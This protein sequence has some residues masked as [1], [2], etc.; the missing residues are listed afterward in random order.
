[1][2]SIA[3]RLAKLSPAK[4]AL[5]QRAKNV[6]EKEQFG[7]VD[8]QKRDRSSGRDALS[9]A[10]QRLWFLDQLE[11][12]NA[13]YNMP[14]AI[15]L[16]GQLDY[17][18]LQRVFD[19]IIQRH[20]SLRTNFQSERGQP[21]QI[22]AKSAKLHISHIDLS[23]LDKGEIE[24]QLETLLRLEAQKP[25]NLARD[26]LLRVSVLRLSKLENV[27]SVTIHHII[28]DGWSVGNVLLHEFKTLYEAF[29]KGEPSP[30]P[31]LKIQYADFASWQRNWL[32][33]SRL[34]NQLSYWKNKLSGVPALIDL[35][36]DRPRPPV[37]TFSG[38][39]HNF[40]LPAELLSEVKALSQAAGCTLFMT[41]L[42][43]FSALLA[44]YSRQEDVVVGS[45]IANRNHPDLEPL[46]G[47]FVNTLV[48]RTSL[49]PETT[50]HELLAQ[51]R[52]NCLEAFQNQDVP[53]ERLVEHLKPERNPSF[54]PL[55]QVMFILQT[56][57]QERTGLK[58]GDL[59]M[60]SIPMDAATSMFDLTL[61]LEEQGGELLGE[62][63]YN[64]ALFD[65]SWIERFVGYYTNMLKG[66][67]RSRD[68]LVARIPLMSESQTKAV[69]FET[70]QTHQ[71]LPLEQSVVSLF[72]EQARQSPN[73]LAVTMGDQSM[74][75]SELNLA[76]EKF[77]SYLCNK[78]VGVETLVGLCLDRSLNMMVG[79]L[80]ILKAGAAY[81]PLDPDYPKERLAAMIESSR[82]RIIVA[83]TATESCLPDAIQT[84]PTDHKDGR[85]AL[86]ILL[87]RDWN[88]ILNTPL[89]ASSPSIAPESLA[90]VIFTSGSTGKPKGVQISHQALLNF[91]LTMQEQPGLKAE[92]VLL[93][94]T[95][96]SFDIA[97]LELYLP[98]ITGA[99]IVLVS[100]ETASDGFQLLKE[101]EAHRPTVMQATPSTW[102]MLLATG[103]KTF[104]MR[105]I[106]CGGEALDSAL[107]NQLVQTGAQIW[108]LYGPTETT[109]WSM[110]NEVK[111]SE[112]EKNAQLGT[113][114]AI[115]KPIGNTQTYILDESLDPSSLGLSGELYI[116]GLGVSRGYLGQPGLTAERFLPDPYSETPGARIY[117]TGDLVRAREEGVITYV[118][119]IDH[120]VKIRGFRIELGEIEATLA[121]H[122]AVSH[123]VA[124]ARPDHHGQ[125]QLVA[126]VETKP[127]WK[128]T[129]LAH[130]RTHA[131]NE[132]WQTVWNETY[133][134]TSVP[135]TSWDDLSGWL[136]SHTRQPIP[137]EEMKEWVT[138]TVS[139]I[140]ALKPQ[141]I[142]E[143][144]CGTGLLLSRL[145]PHV[146]Q[147][148]GLDFSREV[149][150]QLRT[151]LETQSFENVSLL[152][153]E[154]NDLHDIDEESVD[155]FVINSVAQ[156]FPNADYLI[157]AVLGA[158]TKVAD[159][160]RLFIGD[161]R[162]LQMLD[163]QHISVQLFQA[164][165]QCDKEELKKRI[166]AAIEREEE[167]LIH[168]RFF[169]A[170]RSIEPRIQSISLR[171]K[172]GRAHNEMTC[173]RYDL[174]MEI[175]RQP[176]HSVSAAT[177]QAALPEID[178]S[179]HA[180]TLEGLTQSLR[181]HPLGLCLRNVNNQRLQH[182]A[183]T[184]E[185]LNST[186]LPKDVAAF[187][188]KLAQS[189]IE[190]LSI[191][192]M[193]ELANTLGM[194]IGSAWSARQPHR[195]MDIV[196]VK[197]ESNIPMHGIAIEMVYEEAASDTPNFA[198]WTNYPDQNLS[199]Q[200]LT[201]SLRQSLQEALPAY[202]VP[203]S[204]VCLDK[205]P[206]T[207]NGKIDRLSLPAPDAVEQQAAYLAPRNEAEMHLVRIWEDILGIERIG[208]R[209]NF[210]NLG[211][212]SLLA[213]Q[214]ISKIRDYFSIELPLQA[215]FDAPTVGQLAELLDT[216]QPSGSAQAPVIRLLSEQERMHAP[217]SF[218]QQRLW[219]LNE[220]EGA[221]VTYH[222]S[223]AVKIKG[224]LVVETLER[225]FD[226]IVSRHETLRTHF[227]TING[228]PVAKLAPHQPF[229]I[230]RFSVLN[231]TKEQRALSVTQ[232]LEK[233]ATET[234]DLAQDLL[235]RVTLIQTDHHE[236]VMMLTLHHIISDEWSLA[237]LQ[238]EVAKLYAAFS[239]AQS[240]PLPPLPLQ[241]ADYAAWQRQ[242]M[243]RERLAEHLDY[244]VSEL[245]DAP[246]LLELPTDRPR[247]AVQ[248]YIGKTISFR[249]EPSLTSRLRTLGQSCG[250]TLFMT[251]LSGWSI[252][253]SRHARTNDLV[254]GSPV[255]N[256]S[257]SELE[258][259]IGFFVNTV[260]LRM[261]VDGTQSTIEL[262]E[263]NRQKVLDAFKHQD[264]PFE[265]IVEEIKPERNLSH[266]PIF[267]T[268]FVMQNA[269]SA[270][271]SFGG[272]ALEIL[273]QELRAAK[274]D[275]TL[276]IEEHASGLNGVI[277][278]NTD[279]FDASSINRMVE[280][281]EYVLAS[282]TQRPAAVIDSISLLSSYQ[283][284]QL[285]DNLHSKVP[286]ERTTPAKLDTI[287]PS[288][289]EQFNKH[290]LEQPEAIAVR[291]GPLALSYGELNASA[292]KLAAHLRNHG[293]HTYDIVGLYAEPTQEMII[294]LLAILKVGAAYLPLLPGT[295][296]ERLSLMLN[297][298]SAKLVVDATN[299]LST[300]PECTA[301][302]LTL[303]QLAQAQDRAPQ[304]WDLDEQGLAYVIY[305]SGSTGQPKGV[306]VTR[307][308]LAQAT[309]SR[310]NFYS[311]EFS[312]LI[313]LQPFSFDVATGNI[314]WTLCAGATLFM[315]PRSIA[316][317]PQ[318]LLD[319]L[320]R[321]QSSH[322]VL[323]PLLYAPLL[324]LATPEQL[325]ALRTVIVG[326]EQMPLP[327]VQ[328]HKE[329]VP[330]AGLFNEYGPTETT[331]MCCAY[332]CEAHDFEQPIPIGRP[333]PPSK[334][335]LLDPAHHPVPSGL[336]GE[337]CIG[338]P[339]VSMGYLGRPSLT[340]EHFLPD[341]F[342]ESP[343]ARMYRS[344]DLGK[345]NLQGNIEFLGR[346]DHQ[347]KIR[348]FRVELGEIEATLR[349]HPEV[350]ELAV[351]AVQ[352]GSSKRLIAYVVP[353]TVAQD[354][355]H[356]NLLH[357][358][359][360]FAQSLL[361][362]YMVPSAFVLM[363]ALPLTANGKLDQ[364]ALPS[365]DT[366]TP[367]STFTA[368]G[369]E[370]EEKLCKIWGDVLGIKQ[371]GIHDN[372]FMLGGD[373]ILSIQIVSRANQLGLGLSV[374]QLFQHQTIAKL[375]GLIGQGNNRSIEQGPLSGPFLLGPVQ[376]WFLDQ[377]PPEPHH[378]NQSLLLNIQTGLTED[379]L[380]KAFSAIARHHDM[381]RARFI[382]DTNGWQAHIDPI[383][384]C[385]ASVHC[386]DLRDLPV[387]DRSTAMIEH[388]RE[389]QA[390]LDLA[391]GPISTAI[392][393]RLSDEGP[394]KLLWI[395]HHLSVDGISWR[396]LLE[397]LEQALE[398]CH[399]QREISFQSKTDSF[400]TWTRRLAEHSASSECEAELNYWKN[401][402]STAV[403]SLP[404]DTVSVMDPRLN[405]KSSAQTLT[406]VLSA[407]LSEALL[408]KAPSTFRTQI[409]DVLLA[410]L[411]MAL[412]R[413]TGQDSA[414]I[415]LEGHGR[416]EL[417]ENIDISRT[418][419]W[420]T[421]G[422]PVLLTKTPGNNPIDNILHTKTLLQSIPNKGVG[423][424]ILSYLHPDQTVRESLHSGH[425]AQLS[426]NYLGQFKESQASTWILGEALEPTDQEHSPLGLRKPLIEINALHRRDQLEINWTFSINLHHT[427]TIDVL[428]EHFT[429]VLT[430]IV[431]LCDV[432][433]DNLQDL[434]P[435][436]PMQQGMLFH[437]QLG[438]EPGAY[439]IQLSSRMQGDFS[440]SL[441]T[442]A[443]QEVLDRH[444][445]LRAVI[446][447]PPG[448]D[449]LQGI[450]S[451]AKLPWFDFDWR[452]LSAEAQQEQWLAL[453]DAD[454]K[455]GFDAE[456]CPLMRCTLVQTE[457]HS[458]R[459]LWS[460]HHLLTDGWCLPILM[461]EVLECYESFACG[462]PYDAPLPPLYREYIEWLQSKDLNQAKSF[463]RDY[464]QDFD[465][466]TSLGIDQKR[467]LAITSKNTSNAPTDKEP[468]YGS[469]TIALNT[470]TTHS[471]TQLA[472]TQGLTLS[473]LIQSAWSVLLSRYSGSQ[474]VVFGAT[475]SGRPAELVGV[476]QMI[477]LFINTLPVRTRI[478]TNES[479]LAFF[480]RMRDDQLS[481]D[482]YA[483]TPLVDIH[484]CTD[485]PKRHALFESIVIFENYPVDSALD[486]QAQALRID[487][488]EVHEQTGF[489]LTLTA[490]PGECIPLKLSW[491]CSRFEA[492][493]AVRLLEHLTNLLTRLVTALP[494]TVAQWS[495]SMMGVD[496][497][498]QLCKQFNHS[499]RESPDHQHTFFELFERQAQTCPSSIAVICENEKISYGEL[500]AR[501]LKIAASLRQHG[502]M[503]GS[504]IGIYQHRTINMVATL[505]AI[506]S[507]GAAY[508][509]LDPGYPSERIQYM[510][511]DCQALLIV[512]E[513]ALIETLPSTDAINLSIQALVMGSDN[514]SRVE[515]S[516]RQ[517]V[518]YRTK[519]Q[520]LAYMI[521]TSGSTGR[522][523]GVPISH[524]NLT[525]FLLS[526]QRTP[527]MTNR[528]V[529]LAVTTI[530]FDI[531]G[532]E[533][534]LPLITGARI[535]LASREDAVDGGKLSML[536]QDHG[537]TVLQATPTTWRMLLETEHSIASLNK[538]FCGGEGV[539][540][541][542]AQSMVV[543][544][545]EVWNLYGPTETTIWSCAKHIKAHSITAPYEDIGHPI[546]NTEIY[547]VDRELNLMPRG[548]AGELVI[549]GA[550]LSP[551]YWHRP[552]LTAEKFVPNPFAT[553]AS[554]QLYRTGDL[555]YQRADGSLVC[556]GRI[557]HQ[558]KIRGF[559]VE[560]GEIEALIEQHATVKQALVSIWSP[561]PD[562]TR[563]VAYVVSRED[564]STTEM[565]K[566][567][568]RTQLP[569]YM[570]PTE[571]VILESFP[572]TPNGK[573]DR[574]ALP[575]P[576]REF[577][578]AYVEPSTHTEALLAELM[579]QTLQIT[580]ISA[581]DDFFELGG[582]SLLAGRF[583][584][585]VTNKLS[586]QLPLSTI[587]EKSSVKALAQHIDSLL[588]ASKQM[589]PR[590]EV[591][592]DDEEEFRL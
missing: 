557:D 444:P 287:F 196:F 35:P 346:Q 25:F 470:Q 310:L 326:G 296:T 89:R 500:Y 203:A 499:K 464:L 151:R 108:N 180:L 449:P 382:R 381:L 111:R 320:V 13:T 441:F 272:L 313:L 358:F 504:R 550:G 244:W 102:R 236:H 189:Q 534:Y 336:P 3:D 486:A 415:T 19:E 289:L 407:S 431:A 570:V 83:Q 187:R 223:G 409:N 284:K 167:L 238:V 107:A 404:V 555:A 314:F 52:N 91:L 206:L 529:L 265:Y 321:T 129:A 60:T 427:Q 207:P 301:T 237:L 556:L 586:V 297:E 488:V 483:F 349:A 572:L 118:G 85:S 241:F 157:Q 561:R 495:A 172:P 109:I 105:C 507:T 268:M 63:E 68:Q 535:V 549:G 179:Q 377:A 188:E 286:T 416:E 270:D 553:D 72:E 477:G 567:W 530:S 538:G 311:S 77:A 138:Q 425:E 322:L 374:K 515:I 502:A 182:D 467:L 97:G 306:M 505:L 22:I 140:L 162:G 506:Q 329:M 565:L 342:S 325:Q 226:E 185:W 163:L 386:V 516:E 43:G 536:I 435:L 141:R 391:T 327:L 5:L 316:Q 560:P 568:L 376:H 18:A 484:A 156:Y 399:A 388:A 390:S 455:K 34:D 202:M 148:T 254:I 496:E 574:Q 216:N 290:V 78:G 54:T 492:E 288:V 408:L 74:T 248:R 256:R 247:P 545:I 2:S 319:S 36:T 181:D 418:V 400:P 261:R 220:L 337:I 233:E 214:A 174:V 423:F 419:G 333:M 192:T 437:S 503:P 542:L 384:E 406:K 298:C 361:P 147:Y 395:I 547:I 15:R 354:S 224:A 88:E 293:V 170:L 436:S 324:D 64:T 385:T 344:G 21:T 17:E 264:V 106:L 360:E 462:R 490:A 580:R 46:I 139:S 123:A 457:N 494:S 571:W 525:N 39:V 309:L 543:R 158:C 95:T 487:Q 79:L 71:S 315:E 274:F 263:L 161:L 475:V 12:A 124:I 351:V 277:E 397:D 61:K 592:S 112:A 113:G 171:L 583:V 131:L 524:A 357:S 275:L 110:T 29:V 447:T 398:Q 491:E 205:L 230:K 479:L 590:N 193:T 541:E 434:Y 8:I 65:L 120:Q 50:G 370:M 362:E 282:M 66:L 199:K 334:M 136:S 234:F 73:E 166:Q 562:D 453:L 527:G 300:V 45:P 392:R 146:T 116:G 269:P 229:R 405:T 262:L 348:G 501:S 380:F 128:E 393:Y 115:G 489:P 76:A 548:A 458:W 47:F 450:V 383:E 142:M 10:Q 579:S 208:V 424:G 485:I 152:C 369:N 20:E 433:P 372:F 559:R 305:T 459:F 135:E 252:L 465:T 330:Q 493:Q 32:S 260:P 429:N 211:G 401:I 566:E 103:T 127:D 341:P 469:H 512:S 176:V 154:A 414:R 589:S 149:I 92:D 445:S 232:Y 446:V 552:D 242:W 563:L 70:N 285:S 101:I 125:A 258:S 498:E 371:V 11:G 24:R 215:L 417:F 410:A 69:L 292:D 540:Q 581:T 96:I 578:D 526:M 481:R 49:G 213:V 195:T 9:F 519:M 511:D 438:Q 443:W 517:T 432:G 461:R 587:F 474:D 411:M 42:G 93:A 510:L 16:L 250:A 528:D 150:E 183:D 368:A 6:G 452:E 473:L 153:R 57:N 295:P 137:N 584:A 575:E 430:E 582:H 184:Q 75:Y 564:E 33:G 23:F 119:R 364:K 132:K 389:A 51:V 222:I 100:R 40:A 144:G 518:T 513:D 227:V 200:V 356:N 204:I 442:K 87:D 56:Q 514:Q 591:L 257:R 378:F 243:T 186:A 428:A 523:K 82:L 413:W 588:W 422:F 168:P 55:F 240:S 343:G 402:V 130:D 228:A 251:L 225:C 58:I 26:L 532:L 235:L 122:P 221:S 546:D 245:R 363:Q 90:Y 304:P 194:E 350:A 80:G 37:Q 177:L 198:A 331:I 576:G 178:A 454:R 497:V 508:V 303:A 345:I 521:Y 246:T 219:F 312:G 48:M 573:L 210:F 160:G 104:P 340:A 478:D 359:T 335:Y 367:N 281:Y 259:L 159:G 218:S 280:Q 190:G 266:A 143:I 585:A 217:L 544:G 456:T 267:Q 231:E 212:H 471:L 539:S 366:K 339:Q 466:P 209:D 98:L 420:F 451:K 38:A 175:G 318:R 426:F 291:V 283:A 347:V 472:R 394:D 440:P 352:Q 353:Q 551:G 28:S 31:A 323:L 145:A 482:E 134:G 239:Q 328:K 460:H 278:F 533:L 249:I 67:T 173:F 133:R 332:A 201:S 41:L 531:A 558:I 271:L 279:L 191:D 121:E 373:S 30:L 577:H 308:N 468:R 480:S 439:T 94:V 27:V 365:P 273:E 537:V 317:D 126:Y 403:P 197:K 307:E 302:V 276:S 387:E 86:R 299:S 476:E 396:I 448:L 62:F 522:P 53:F 164:E 117:R 338:G 1:M 114:A 44:R 255:T 509:P 7:S 412:N 14:I 355:D 81:I 294:S 84:S 554:S 253:L 421:S 99:R 463:W 59:S 520:D 169:S 155:T 165:D 4:R 569:A 375:S 379:I